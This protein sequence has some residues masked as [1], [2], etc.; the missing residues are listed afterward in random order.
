MIK[1]YKY[2][3]NYLSQES[4]ADVKLIDG[5]LTYFDHNGRIVD[6]TAFHNDNIHYCSSL[7]PSIR[8]KLLLKSSDKLSAETRNGFLDQI[9]QLSESR[10]RSKER[11][12]IAQG[13]HCRGPKLTESYRK[14]LAKSTSR[15]L[16][17]VR[18]L[19]KDSGR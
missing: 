19:C 5:V 3:H 12:G 10:E 15:V 2:G 4:Q 17:I 9:D 7:I 6:V 1:I 11:L 18:S 13:S 8:A 16:A 14:Q